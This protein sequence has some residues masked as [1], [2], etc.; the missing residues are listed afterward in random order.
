MERDAIIELAQSA[1]V[2]GVAPVEAGG[3]VCV[4]AGFAPPGQK[5]E[6][7]GRTPSGSFGF[8]FFFGVLGDPGVQFPFRPVT[9][10][11]IGKQVAIYLDQDQISAPVVAFK[12]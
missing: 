9:G 5:H 3:R 2:V 8:D 10:R 7:D 12:A 6:G 1:L 4:P 11:N